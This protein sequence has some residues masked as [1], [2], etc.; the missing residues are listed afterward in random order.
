MKFDPNEI[1]KKYRKALRK[2]RGKELE[3]K[4]EIYYKR[5]WFYIGFAQRFPDGSVGV[6]SSINGAT[7]HRRKDLLHFIEGVK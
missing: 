4:T 3:R 2:Q 5:G 1:I 6:I 7:P